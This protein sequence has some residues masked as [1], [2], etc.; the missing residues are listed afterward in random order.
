MIGKISEI[1]EIRKGRGV[2]PPGNEQR[3]TERY[4]RQ[5]KIRRGGQAPLSIIKI[6]STFSRR[7]SERYGLPDAE[8]MYLPGFRLSSFLILH[9]IRQKVGADLGEIL[10]CQVGRFLEMMIQCFLREQTLSR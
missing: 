10:H 1:F 9:F 8:P 7:G 6:L 3:G 2:D 4:N 5:I